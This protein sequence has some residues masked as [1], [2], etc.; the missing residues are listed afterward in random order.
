MKYTIYMTWSIH[1]IV[2]LSFLSA[3]AKHHILNDFR[4]RDLFVNPY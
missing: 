1:A 2:L 3:F 4:V